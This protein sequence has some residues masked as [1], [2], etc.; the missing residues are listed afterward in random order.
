MLSGQLPGETDWLS[1]WW[2]L[3]NAQH[4]QGEAGGSF[5]SKERAQEFEAGSRRKSREKRQVFLE[6]LQK[7]LKPHETVLDIG[8]GTGRLAI[9]LAK[10]AR[11]VTVVEPAKAMSDI[12]LEKSHV[13]GLKNIRIIQKIWEEAEV[14]PHDIA[15]CAHAMY[16]STDFAGFVRKMEK[17]A[18]RRC[19]LSLRLITPTGIMAEISRD[20]YGNPN[21]SPNFIIAYNALYSMGIFASVLV[22]EDVFHWTSSDIESAL[23]MAKRHL[24]LKSTNEHDKHIRSVLTR[25]LTFKDGSYVWPDGMCGAYVWWQPNRT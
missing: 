4:S 16:G 18:R 10:V 2:G 7:D 25:R 22:E 11:E 12:L 6:L 14:V 9:P 21:D 3:A 5:A 8:G 15:I 20:I 13:E 17:S 24:Y 1:L 23:E 19:Y